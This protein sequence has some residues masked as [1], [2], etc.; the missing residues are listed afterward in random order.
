MS[1]T[2]QSP[3]P[4]FEVTALVDGAFKEVSLTDFHG[5]WWLFFTRFF[6]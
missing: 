1:P 3:A 5:Q 6:F 2:I 4:V